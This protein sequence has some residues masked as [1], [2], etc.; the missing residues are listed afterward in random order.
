VYLRTAPCSRRARKGRWGPIAGIVVTAL[1]DLEEKALAEIAAV[2]LEELA[3]F[4]AVV[5]DVCLAQPV[6]QA[7]GKVE[8]GF[9][10]IIVVGRYLQR[11]EAEFGKSCGGFEDVVAGEGDALDAGAKALGDEMAGDRPCCFP[12]RS[13]SGAGGRRGFRRL[14][15]AQGPPERQA[16]FYLA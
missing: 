15:C 16:A 11:P 3:A 4:V 1:G 10:V 9:E 7:G 12:R 14:G 6:D 2:E 5:E 13:E 8:A